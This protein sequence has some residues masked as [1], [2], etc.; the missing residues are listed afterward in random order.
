MS[1]PNEVIGADPGIPII[2]SGTTL[3]GSATGPIGEII[4]ISSDG[5]NADDIEVST[6]NNTWLF[7][8]KSFIGGLGDPGS[9][10]FDCIWEPTNYAHAYENFGGAA[11]SGLGSNATGSFGSFG[12]GYTPANIGYNE[13]WTITFPD[14]SSILCSGYIK[15]I[16]LAVP[17]EQ[18][19]M[20]PITVRFSG[21]LAFN[22]VSGVPDNG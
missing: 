1:L 6:M 7:Y 16:G 13:T 18:K 17:M 21:V 2:G 5:I 3:Q 22:N 19:I 20:A 15:R 8:M 10:T 14:G 4:N 11:N 9:M 12:A